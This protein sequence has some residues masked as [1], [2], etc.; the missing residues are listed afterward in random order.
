MINAW[1]TSTIHNKAKNKDM[2]MD[3]MSTISNPNP[4]NFTNPMGQRPSTANRNS[5][6]SL[7]AEIEDGKSSVH[8]TTLP[9]QLNPIAERPRPPV[10]NY[11]TEV[12]DK[13]K[14]VKSPKEGRKQNQGRVKK[15]KKNLGFDEPDEHAHMVYGTADTN[16]MRYG[17]TG[18]LPHY[19]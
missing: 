2:T 9:P 16:P 7:Y 13:A 15:G 1:G 4:Y 5:D 6:G 11:G 8:S 19:R 17:Y 14:L 12:K 10:R 3:N 18:K